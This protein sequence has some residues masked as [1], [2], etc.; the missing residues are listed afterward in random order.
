MSSDFVA[1]GY[2]TMKKLLIASIAVL[3]LATPAFA[4]FSLLPQLRAQYSTT[5][6]PGLTVGGIAQL[7]G[8]ISQNPLAVD[9]LIRPA[10]TYSRDLVSS[11]DLLVSGFAQLRLPL[12]IPIT[13]SGDIGFAINPRAGLDLTYTLNPMLSILGNVTLNT[14]LPIVPSGG[15]FGWSLLGLVEADFTVASSTLYAG[16]SFDQI[17]P[18]FQASLYAGAIYPLTS[19]I[20]LLAELSTGDLPSGSISNGYLLLRTTFRF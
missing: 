10:I 13:P 6:V 18:S 2:K 8:T 17:A 7:G 4:Q 14:S 16:L 12:T 20:D 5:V 19:S 9:I 3:G 15:S 1:G 11:G